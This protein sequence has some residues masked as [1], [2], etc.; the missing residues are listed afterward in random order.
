MEEYNTK[1][2]DRAGIVSKWQST[3]LNST[4]AGDLIWQFNDTLSSEYK[5]VQDGYGVL[6]SE[7]A[8]SEYDVL[9]TQHAGAMS[10]KV[11]GG[12]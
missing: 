7:V 1:V 4:L 8:G 10:A 5:P 3:V 2:S 9:V 12:S 6:Y 11:V